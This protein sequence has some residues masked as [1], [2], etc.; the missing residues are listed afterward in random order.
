MSK[1][2]KATSPDAA[3]DRPSLIRA[4]VDRMVDQTFFFIQDEGANGQVCVK[5]ELAGPAIDRVLKRFYPDAYAADQALTKVFDEHW[6]ELWYQTRE[7]AFLVGVEYGRRLAGGVRQAPSA[8]PRMDT[9]AHGASIGDRLNRVTRTL[10]LIHATAAALRA[11]VKV[12][13]HDGELVEA[14]EGQSA[15]CLADLWWVECADK[16]LLATPA[17]TADEREELERD[18]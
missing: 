10:G 16:G 4:V 12:E 6:N 14:I 3:L 2:K 17:P 7:A 8:A 15:A 9:D 5:V 1:Q 18:R 11:D 13:L